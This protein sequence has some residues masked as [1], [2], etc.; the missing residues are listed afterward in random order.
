M[1]VAACGIACDV[2]ALYLKG[3]CLTCAAGTESEALKKLE[4]QRQRIN[5]ECPVLS[6]AVEK[7][8]GYCL[9]DCEEFPCSKFASGFK[10]EP[11]KGTDPFPYSASFL[12]MYR[13]R[14]GRA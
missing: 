2:C 10:Y 11:G 6:C 1:P 12:E 5:T 14:F 8:V 9:R 3:T 7:K 13:E 4:S